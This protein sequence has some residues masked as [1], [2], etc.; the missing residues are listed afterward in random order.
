MDV[1][2]KDYVDKIFEERTASL[3]VTAKYLERQLDH[4]NDLRKEVTNDRAD[5]LPRTEYLIHHQMLEDKINDVKSFQSKM[6][7]IG[8]ALIFLSAIIGSVVAHIFFK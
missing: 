3:N 4:L 1:S 6:V 8:L 5:F 2:I 7:G